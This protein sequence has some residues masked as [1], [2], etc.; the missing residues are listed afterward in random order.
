MRRAW[1]NLRLT[2]PHRVAIFSNGLKRHGFKVELGLPSDA[3]TGDMLVTWN[4]IGSGDVMAKQFQASGLPVLVAENAAWGNRFGGDDWYTIARGYHNTQG[5][6]DVGGHDRWDSLGVAMEP[7][8]VC[9]E[10]VILPQRGIG[11]PPVAMP[12]GWA[13]NALRRYGGRIRQ[14][15]GTRPSV[16]LEID[17][18][19]ACKVVTW[20]SGAAIRASLWGCSVHS[21]MPNWIGQHENSEDGR[22]EMFR[23]LAWA[24]W[25]LS[26]IES[27]EAFARLGVR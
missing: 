16:P 14:H 23:R 5:C 22:L 18:G 8:R 2:L 6:F 21:E 13:E 24:Q 9:G 12:R 7:L 20:G 26:E 19:G 10:T 15:P 11:S 25:R 4:R 27:G 3:R 17:L 1:L